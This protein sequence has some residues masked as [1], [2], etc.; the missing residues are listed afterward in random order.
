MLTATVDGAAWAPDAGALDLFA[1]LQSGRAFIFARRLL[2]GGQ[3]EEMLQIEF[4]TADPFRRASYRLTGGPAAF[5]TFRVQTGPSTGAIYGTDSQ[6]T[7]SVAI[8]TADATDS[9][10]AGSFSF[11]AQQ[12]GGTAVRRI[13]GQFR[14]RYTTTVP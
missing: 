9:V 8:Q 6:H 1:L 3:T 11:E 7:G 5:A 4:D 10:V 14:V 12:L 13:A 2:D